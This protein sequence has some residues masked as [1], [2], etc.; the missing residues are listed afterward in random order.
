MGAEF[1]S[2]FTGDNNPARFV[3]ESTGFTLVRRFS[4]MRKKL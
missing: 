2:L 3:Y 1:M 4:C